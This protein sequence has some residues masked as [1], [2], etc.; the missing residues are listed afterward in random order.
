MVYFRCTTGSSGGK[1]K[2]TVTCNNVFAGVTI[3]CSDGTTTLTKTCP[4]SSPYTVVF[5]IPNGGTWTI[6]GV[7]GGKTNTTTVVIPDTAI[8]NYIP[9][10]STVTPTGNIQTWLHCAN[11][12]DKTYTTIDQVLADASTLQALIASNN[13]ADYMA[14]STTWVSSV[15]ADSTAMTYIGANDYC[16]NKLLANSTWCTAIANSTYFESVLNV[17]IPVMTSATAP[18]GVVSASSYTTTYV[19]YLAFN[20]DFSTGSSN[21]GWCPGNSPTFG[22]AYVQYQFATAGIIPKKMKEMYI[23]RYNQYDY[24][25]KLQGSNTGNSNDW[26]NLDAGNKLN[27]NQQVITTLPNINTGYKYLRWVVMS[28]ATAPSI[29]NGHGFKLQVWGRAA[30]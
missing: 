13:A 20:G 8:L 16:A 28:T 26:T 30:S 29:T 12:W 3:T 11:I 10:G 9:T 6:S 1:W 21:N 4:S 27:Y 7:Y 17:K 14:R 24:T 5:N 15:C 19:P 18:S 2:L 23:N 25:L 22:N